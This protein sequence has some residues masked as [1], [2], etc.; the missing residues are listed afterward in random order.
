MNCTF[1]SKSKKSASRT[2]KI[3]LANLYAHLV[4]NGFLQLLFAAQVLFGRL[5]GVVTEEELYLVQLATA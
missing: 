4:V 1:K 3:R 2:R 5:D